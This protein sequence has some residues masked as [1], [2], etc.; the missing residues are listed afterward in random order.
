[1]YLNSLFVHFCKKNVCVTFTNNCLQFSLLHM[2]EL[3]IIPFL[4]SAHNDIYWGSAMFANVES[5]LTR[6]GV[7]LSI[8]LFL[9]ISAK[10]NRSRRSIILK[11]RAAKS[12]CRRTAVTRVHFYANMTFKKSSNF[13][14]K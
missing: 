12:N 7:D 11:L 14:K 4:R 8:I 6:N 13:S 1:M 5:R 10:C 9:A 3:V 2:Q